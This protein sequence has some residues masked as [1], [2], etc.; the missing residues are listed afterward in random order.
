MF[1]FN[2][3][4][5]RLMSY[6]RLTVIDAGG[7]I[8]VYQGEPTDV[9]PPVTIRLHDRSIHWRLPL[10]PAMTV[11]ESYMDGTLTIEEGTLY[12]FLAL[13]SE[14]LHRMDQ[15]YSPGEHAFAMVRLLQQWNPVSSSKRN[16]A[17]H[18]DLSGALYDL[19]LDS[20]REYSCAYFATAGMSLEE[21]QRAKKTHIMT[22]LLLRPGQKVL[23]IGCGWGGLALSM[24]RDYDVDV[25]G[26]TLSEEQLK[27]ARLRAEDA[28]LTG[29]VHF[30]LC[31]Y[32]D[33]AERFDRIVSVG[34]FEH[35]GVGY[36]QTF[37]NHVRDLLTDNGVALLHAIGRSA[38]PGVTNAWIRK[39]IF[40]GGYSPALSEVLPKVERAGLLVTDI[41]LLFPH[42]A[43][44]LHHWAE[45]FAKNRASAAKIYDERFCRMW[46]F[47]L[48]GAETAFRHQGLMVF[49]MQ[50]AKNHADI[51][52]TRDYITA[53]ERC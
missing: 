23:D 28:Q 19:F 15:R 22:K 45:R 41:E 48:A 35:V 43:E 53:R 46:E 52:R 6:G 50:M 30:R 3:F 13:V 21:A 20:D 38:G 31:D 40:P 9:F 10:R 18:Y 36:F 1:L 33:I 17:R 5:N 34:M 7:K 25:T 24:A 37:F 16:V 14:N 26:I 8:H 29:K 39:Y 12:D 11:G 2:L 47:Y 42:Y 4:F 51:P 49:Q 32:R 27:V 44:T